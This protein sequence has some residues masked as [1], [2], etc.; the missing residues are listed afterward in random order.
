MVERQNELSKIQPKYIK[1]CTSYFSLVAD[2]YES[3]GIGVT[4]GEIQ[5]VVD[6][7]GF[8]LTLNPGHLIHIDEWMS[9]PFYNTSKCTLKSGMAI[10]ADMIPKMLPG[11]LGNNLEDTVVIADDKLRQDLK[12]KYPEAYGRIEQRRNF[13]TE[14]LGIKIKPEVLSLSNY[15]I[16]LRPFLL[17]RDGML[18]I[19]R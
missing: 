16:V 2:W 15:P 10:Q 9:T 18:K 17:D 8:P 5:D 4:G 12:E 11:E 1:V 19:V 7:T 13:I 3:I 6:A 14:V